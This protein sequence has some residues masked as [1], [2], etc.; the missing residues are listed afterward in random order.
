MA[1]SSLLSPLLPSLSRR[2]Q[3][4]SLLPPSIRKGQAAVCRPI[5]L[6]RVVGDRILLAHDQ[7]FEIS[8]SSTDHELALLVAH[9]QHFVFWQFLHNLISLSALS[10]SQATRARG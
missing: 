2:N 1:V 10:G 4:N 7:I 8:G 6:V 3:G 5:V 9:K